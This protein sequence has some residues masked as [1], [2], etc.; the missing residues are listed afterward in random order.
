VAQLA[1]ADAGR[2]VHAGAGPQA[3]DALAFVLALD[4]ALED[5]DELELGLV[6]VR[7]ARDS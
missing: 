4:P 2:L 5:V 7:L 1:V 6:Q 3:H